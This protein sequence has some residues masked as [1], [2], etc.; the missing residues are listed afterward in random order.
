MTSNKSTANTVNYFLKLV[1][2]RTLTV[3]TEEKLRATDA[4]LSSYGSN[5]SNLAFVCYGLL[6]I[7]EVLKR[8]ADSSL[9]SPDASLT[10]PGALLSAQALLKTLLGSP[11]ALVGTASQLRSLSDLISDIRIFNRLWGL[12]PLSVW[13]VD[14][15]K[16]PPSD[17]VL[18]F[19][20]YSQVVVNIIYQPLENVAYLAMHNVLDNSSK[21]FNSYAQGKLWI[22][23]CYFWAAHVVLDFFRLYREYSLVKN[24]KTL[25]VEQKQA[26][27][28]ANK[29]GWIQGLIINISYLPLTVHWSLEQ[30]C[31]N[32]MTVGFL[33]ATAAAAS[34]FPRWKQIFAIKEEEPKEKSE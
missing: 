16:S 28:K 6:F 8:V 21:Y 31:L 5:D 10:S 30:G 20:A 19:I 11:K 26:K 17:P 12:I 15:F 18:R 24:D 23:S 34:I 1:V 2:P 4:N 32:D 14:T 22:Y 27:L 3:N 29:F 25:T 33:G 9:F 7:S 13:A